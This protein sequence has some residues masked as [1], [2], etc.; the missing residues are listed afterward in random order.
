[1]KRYL[2]TITLL[3]VCALSYAQEGP[4]S[5]EIKAVLSSMEEQNGPLFKDPLSAFGPS[6]MEELQLTIAERDDGW[7]QGVQEWSPQDSVKFF[8]D[9]LG[10]E[11]A[12]ETLEYSFGEWNLVARSTNNY[13]DQGLVDTTLNEAYEQDEW[14]PSSRNVLTYNDEGN[15]LEDRTERWSAEE[16]QPLRRTVNTYDDE[17]NR[18]ETVRENWDSSMESWIPFFKFEF[19]YISG[20]ELLFSRNFLIWNA[21]LGDYF[22]SSRIEFYYDE[23][24]R[25]S[26]RLDYDG[27]GDE[28]SLDER[29]TFEYESPTSDVVTESI[30]E[31]YIDGE[32]ELDRRF[33]YIY[34]GNVTESYQEDWDSEAEDWTP[35]N[36]TI[37]EGDEEGRLIFRLSRVWIDSTSSYQDEESIEWTFNDDN[38]VRIIKRRDAEAGELV[39]TSRN[40]RFYTT[41]VSTEEQFAA[42]RSLLLY[43]NPN[44]GI[45]TVDL[46]NT[47]LQR[48]TSLQLRCTDLQGRTIVNRDIAPAGSTVEVSLPNVPTGTYVLYLTDGQQMW[49]QKIVI[50]R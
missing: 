5:E 35:I 50:Q 2:L 27:N 7:S 14:Q 49:Q 20:T 1:M 31:S 6:S 36:L 23:Q 16:W 11:T 22:N 39:N 37:N 26:Y 12:T 44:P 38:R 47:S 24:E 33:R 4:T 42:D 30:I 18:T 29:R 15:V 13:N 17:G 25:S 10:R 34:D 40:T 41:I 45:F 8:Y 9:E 48:S 32:W 28:W 19:E 3:G 21:G 43:P 46:S